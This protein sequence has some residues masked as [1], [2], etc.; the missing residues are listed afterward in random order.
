M[1]SKTKFQSFCYTLNIA[2]I[3]EMVINIMKQ[4]GT[5]SISKVLLSFLQA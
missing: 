1:F 5:V 4:I 2:L 3:T